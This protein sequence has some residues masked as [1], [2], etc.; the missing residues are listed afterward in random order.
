M[1]L[2]T[3]IFILT[4]LL[5]QFL[6]FLKYSTHV[7]YLT[8]ISKFSNYI[9]VPYQ[10]ISREDLYVNNA[11]ILKIKIKVNLILKKNPN[12]CYHWVTIKV[13]SLKLLFET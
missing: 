10:V 7:F 2:S 1:E 8:T 3:L 9:L 11:E 13:G 12:L 4:L 5:K 6:S